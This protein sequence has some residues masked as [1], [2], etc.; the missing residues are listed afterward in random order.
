MRATRNI[1]NWIKFGYVIV[2]SPLPKVR[3]QQKEV[4]PLRMQRGAARLP[5]IGSTET[6][7]PYS[8]EKCNPASGQEAGFAAGMEEIMR[9]PVR[10]R[11]CSLHSS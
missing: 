3:G 9:L 8:V 5:F 4:S 2:W 11:T 7:I 6:T 1:Q 10:C